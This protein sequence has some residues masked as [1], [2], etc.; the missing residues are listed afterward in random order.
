V[1][2]RR[3]GREGMPELVTRLPAEVAA[4]LLDVVDAHARAVKAAGDPRPIGLLRAEI[5]ANLILRPWDA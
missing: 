5:A 3:T 2:L 4:A 1:F